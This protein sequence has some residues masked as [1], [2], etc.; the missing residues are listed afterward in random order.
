MP[1]NH[2]PSL[3]HTIW[4]EE[5]NT[6]FIYLPKVACTSWKIFFANALGL[7]LPDNYAAVHQFQSLPLPYVITMPLERQAAFLNGVDDGTITLTAVLREPRERILSAYLDKI[8][9]HGNPRSYFSLQVLP[10][11]RSHT[12]LAPG[13]CPT[14][15]QFLDWIVTSESPHRHNDHWLPMCTILGLASPIAPV[16]SW[17]FWQ[18]HNLTQAADYFNQLL[19]TSVPFPSNESLSHR[20]SR[21]SATKLAGMLT[22]EVEQRMQHLYAA[23]LQLY[24][25]AAN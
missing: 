23:D 17:R 6:A 21:D 5:H 10:D 24:A 25:I 11:I 7:K 19:Q 13:T 16:G 9:L 15:E 14:F 4:L 20:P 18:M 2:F 8:K 3:N 12:G 1:A 22:P